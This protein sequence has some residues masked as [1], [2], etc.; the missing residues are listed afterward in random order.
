[1]AET[2]NA[3]APAVAYTE[4]RLN[5]IV[6]IA[7]HAYRPGEI[8]VVDDATLAQIPSDAILAQKPAN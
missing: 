6:V 5:R 4:V 8:H 7:G 2:Q 1:M 3:T